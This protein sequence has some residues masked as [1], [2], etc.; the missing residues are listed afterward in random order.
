MDDFFATLNPWWPSGRA[1][2]HW[3]LLPDPARPATIRTCPWPTA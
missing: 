2:L 3:H 1:D